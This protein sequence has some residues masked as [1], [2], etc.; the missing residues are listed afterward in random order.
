MT[1]IA[2]R[3]CAGTRL[4][5]VLSL[6]RTPLAN[7][8]LKAGRFSE[9]EVSY[10]LDVVFCEECSLVQ[11]TETVPPEVLFK[12]YVYRSSFSA[13]MLDHA[14]RLAQRLVQERSLT[15]DSLVVEIASN[16]GYLLQ[17]YIESDVPVLG[18]EPA[19]NI[20][21]IAVEEKGVRT[22]ARFFS[23]DLASSLRADGVAA[24]VIHANNVLAHVSDL[25]GVVAGIGILL[26]AD[27]VAVIEAPYVKD[28]IDHTE[29]D[30]IYHEHLCYFSATSLAALFARH[31]LA[32]VDVE[33]LPIHGGSL[34]IFVQH[35]A[36]ASRAPSVARL[37]DEEHASRLTDR[38]Y[39]EDFGTRVGA[40]KAELTQLL[41]RLKS[42]GKR[43]A[44]YGASAKGSTLLNYMG[45]GGATLDYVV[46]R[47]PLKQGLY[48]P[49]SRLPV[50][51][52]EHLLEDRPDYV[53]LL[54][55]NFADE[56]LEQQR[57][58]RDMGGRFV[59]PIPSVS[60]V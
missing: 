60:V 9:P 18:I 10:P 46:D 28:L 40:L 12:E 54:T 16:D 7:A 22:L 26:K 29:F 42:E 59:I 8:L 35:E 1:E 21:R 49:G 17:N 34:R 55:W 24:D 38:T 47:S 32:I 41:S 2:C 33:R 20:A 27:G 48:T 53:L 36:G 44:A 45:I 5:L 30:T 58:F 14:R 50:Y 11:I 43:I 56:I 51:A 52:P 4:S 37:L 15:A 13:T 6:G 57:E 3:S 39:Y 23:S 25:N 31:R 19:E